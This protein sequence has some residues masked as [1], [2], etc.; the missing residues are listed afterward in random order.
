MSGA[1]HHELKWNAD[2]PDSHDHFYQAN[3]GNLRPIFR[4]VNMNVRTPP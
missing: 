3:Q 4:G 1:H 2:S